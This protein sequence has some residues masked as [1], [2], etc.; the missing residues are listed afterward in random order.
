[1]S[2]R[3]LELVLAHAGLMG[4][5]LRRRLIIKR[6]RTFIAVQQSLDLLRILLNLQIGFSRTLSVSLP[7]SNTF[8]T[9]AVT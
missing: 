4:N 5:D 6:Q 9:L 3:A 2:Y 7:S 1:M 8:T